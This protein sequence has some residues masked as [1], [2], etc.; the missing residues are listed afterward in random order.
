MFWASVT[1]AI[2]NKDYGKATILKQAL[3]DRQRKKAAERSAANEEWTP[4]FFTGAVTPVGRPD[5][6]QEGLDALQGLH[7][8]NFKLKPSEKLGA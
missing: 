4:R 2:H 7:E 3:E 1:E 5:L 8:G 6:T